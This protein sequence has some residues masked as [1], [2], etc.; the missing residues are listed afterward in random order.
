MTSL[1]AVRIETNK[2]VIMVTE[3]QMPSI[4]YG[5]NEDVN[6]STLIKQM[7]AMAEE[8]RIRDSSSGVS[9]Q[10]SVG[11]RP[12]LDTCVLEQHTLSQ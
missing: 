9:D 6:E 8:L 2:M 5:A 3:S 10:Q 11:L 12:S 4:Q 7:H 1:S